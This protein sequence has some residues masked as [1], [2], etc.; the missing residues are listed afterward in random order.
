MSLPSYQEIQRLAYQGVRLEITGGM[1]TWEAL[2]GALHQGV[3]DDIRQSLTRHNAPTKPCGCYH[4]AATYIEFAPNLLRRPDIALFCSKPPRPDGAI[5]GLI[6]EAVIEVL[7]L[8][9]EQKD[10]DAVA[11]YLAAGVQDVLLVDPRHA[12][13]EWHCLAVARRLY[14]LPATLQLQMGCCVPLER[15]GE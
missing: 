5:T 1:P 4:I 6:P 12:T 9:Y 15:V 2:P 13:V 11:L 10:R 3:V 14:D 7:S 8:G